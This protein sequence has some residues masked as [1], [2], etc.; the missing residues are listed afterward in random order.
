M[1]AAPV[2]TSSSPEE[3]RQHAA[4]MAMSGVRL[5]LLH[6][7]LAAGKTEWAKGFVSA[8][9][10]TDSVTSPTFTL[11]HEYQS[12]HGPIHHWDLYRLE[13]GTDWDTL[14]LTELLSGPRPILVEWPD[15]FPGPWPAD[16]WH[17]SIE[18][19]GEQTR[20]LRASPAPC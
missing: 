7:D 12:P 15:R 2:T 18:W 6:G 20:T 11:A 1:N 17:V 14:G 10:S 13:H 8:L 3:T 9:G 4:R 5:V 16:A 19:T